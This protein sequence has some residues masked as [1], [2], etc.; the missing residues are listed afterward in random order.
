MPAQPLENHNVTQ[1]WMSRNPA[2]LERV[3][4][5]GAI[6]RGAFGTSPTTAAISPGRAEILGNHTDYNHG[7]TLS[8][9]IERTFVIIGATNNQNSVR[10]VS[11]AQPDAIQTIPLP[12]RTR[13]QPLFPGWLN[14]PTGVLLA[15]QQH[16]ATAVGFDAVFDSTIPIGAG[17]SSSAALEISFAWLVNEL[18]HLKLSPIQL[19]AAGRTAEN[20]FL[21]VPSGYLDQATVQLA[22]EALLFL[23][24][25]S[26]GPR[27]FIHERLEPNL[28][29]AGAQFVVGFDPSSRHHLTDSG[30]QARRAACELA[31]QILEPLLARPLASL[32]QVQPEEWQQ[33]R[34]ALIPGIP[35]AL[36]SVPENSP[37]KHL[38][39]TSVSGQKI[40]RW[41]D[42]IFS[43]NQ[44]VAQ[45]RLILSQRL[46]SRFGSLLV[47]SG[48]SAIDNF[49]IAERSPQLPWVYDTILQNQSGW[50]VL[51]IRNMG[52]G[53]NATTLMLVQAGHLQRLEQ[54]FSKQYQ[55][56]F[57]AP[58]QFIPFDPAPAAGLL[59]SSLL[60]K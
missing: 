43:E 13:Q 60:E 18:H 56:Q 7:L 21:S 20:Q 26:E 28:S 6:F 9:A 14:Y 30:Y 55:R 33:Y 27:P 46:P 8:A 19:I 49:E 53:F 39:A 12:A 44:R 32:R 59:E 40:I 51:G 48:R 16:A 42:H 15:L 35:R 10:L 52:G 1:R 37:L 23:D 38:A 25:A 50:G 41:V 4:K 17:V 34:S 11:A 31:R 24:H 54:E 2:L 22:N 3:K 36:G 58:Y 5:L 29:A 47:H 45:A 57:H